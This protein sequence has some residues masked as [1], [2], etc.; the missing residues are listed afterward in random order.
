MWFTTTEE[1][2]NVLN[3]YQI[4]DGCLQLNKEQKQNYFLKTFSSDFDGMHN[5]HVNKMLGLLF[6]SFSV[7]C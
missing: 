4:V 3:Q 5:L 1:G 2:K 7:D 6:I